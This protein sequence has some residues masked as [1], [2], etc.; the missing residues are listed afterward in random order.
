M[1][2][3]GFPVALPMVV[4][5]MGMMRNALQTVATGRTVFWDAAL[6]AVAESP[7]VGSGAW[8]YTRA[9]LDAY[10][11]TSSFIPMHAHNLPLQMLADF[12]LLGCLGGSLAIGAIWWWG[13]AGGGRKPAVASLLA[14][15]VHSATDVPGAEVLWLAGLVLGMVSTIERGGWP[16][17]SKWWGVGLAAVSIWVGVRALLPTDEETRLFRGSLAWQAGHPRE[18]E[19]IWTSGGAQAEEARRASLLSRFA[20][21]STGSDWMSEAAQAAQKAPW[22]PLLALCRIHVLWQA[23]MVARG[24][25][26]LEAQA[27]RWP[28]IQIHWIAYQ[29]YGSLGD[30]MRERRSLIE[31]MKLDPSVAGLGVMPQSARVIDSMLH[32]NVAF[33]WSEASLADLRQRDSLR[34]SRACRIASLALTAQSIGPPLRCVQALGRMP[35]NTWEGNQPIRHAPDLHELYAYGAR[36][37]P[38]LSVLCWEIV[39]RGLFAKFVKL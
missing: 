12:G 1:G 35:G 32:A 4:Q 16:R 26:L 37:P 15:W 31:A 19:G 33:R 13:R 14:L 18:A 10:G 23:G 5:G 21:G 8:S 17:L 34:A 22:H 6:R 36:V 7:F 25:S 2:I 24:D 27:K 9:Y 30:T 39:R 28:T 3:I 11:L 20:R 38:E 29:R